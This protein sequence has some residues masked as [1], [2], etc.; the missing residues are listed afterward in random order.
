MKAYVGRKT[1]LIGMLVYI[2]KTG[3]EVS[4]ESDT[5]NKKENTEARV[6]LAESHCSNEYP[7]G[8]GLIPSKRLWLISWGKLTPLKKGGSQRLRVPLGR[9]G[10]GT[11]RQEKQEVRARSDS[12]WAPPC[13]RAASF[14]F[15]IC[16]TSG[17][18]TVPF[19]TNHGHHVQ[20]LQADS[21]SQVMWDMDTYTNSSQDNLFNSRPENKSSLV[22]VFLSQNL[23]TPCHLLPESSPLL[24][25]I[26]I[27]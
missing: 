15:F 24:Y 19:I 1:L 3:Q 27:G 7:L 25:P 5:I 23:A 14:T 11:S 6:D 16:V 4:G 21:G 12:D 20:M 8:N 17:N 18:G 13:S 9:Q 2:P 10:D 22:S 26:M